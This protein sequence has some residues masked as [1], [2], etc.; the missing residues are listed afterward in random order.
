MLLQDLFASARLHRVHKF[1]FLPKSAVH[2]LCHLKSNN[3]IG[4]RKTTD[5]EKTLLSMIDFV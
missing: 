1:F 5:K 3:I 4:Q 2:Y